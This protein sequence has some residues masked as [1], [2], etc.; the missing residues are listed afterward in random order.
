[1]ANVIVEPTWLTIINPNKEQYET[2]VEKRLVLLEKATP[3][4]RPQP[5]KTL[6]EVTALFIWKE[7]PAHTPA[8]AYD[9]EGDVVKYLPTP[10]GTTFEIELDL[11]FTLAATPTG[12]WWYGNFTTTSGKNHVF[13]AEQEGQLDDNNSFTFL[14]NEHN[15]A[16]LIGVNNF[17]GMSGSFGLNY[18]N[19]NPAIGFVIYGKYYGNSNFP[20][21]FYEITLPEPNVLAGDKVKITFSEYTK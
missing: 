5:L 3:I 4:V 12:K 1:M 21:W 16:I 6:D 7:W 11:T 10:T 15:S 9:A 19:G 17:V 8:V 18:E 14:Y 13:T 2:L 20:S